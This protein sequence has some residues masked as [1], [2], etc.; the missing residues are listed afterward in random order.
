MI[1]TVEQAA[2]ILA[3][4]M[5]PFHEGSTEAEQLRYGVNCA[6]LEN[7]IADALLRGEVRPRHPLNGRYDDALAFMGV[8]AH[9]AMNDVIRFLEDQGM[10]LP[11]ADQLGAEPTERPARTDAEPTQEE[12]RQDEAGVRTDGLVAWQAA[13]IESWPEITKE[14]KGR[15]PARNAMK[16]LKK[17]GPRDVFPAEQP[18]LDALHWIDR[19]K[20]PQTVR[21]KSVATRISEWR[22]A[23][24][25]P[26]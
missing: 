21:Y 1:V 12:A 6:D 23:G 2:E 17:H 13:M 4:R 11:A 14:H 25:I 15:P 16:W 24:K 10:Q 19:D 26:A 8:Q 22:K 18:D 20:N 3:Q 9:V 7:C 5:P